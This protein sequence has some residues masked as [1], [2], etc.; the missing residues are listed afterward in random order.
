MKTITRMTLIGGAVAVALGT[1]LAPSV[2]LADSGEHYGK[3]RGG[4]GA[5]MLERYDSNEDGALTQAEIDAAREEQRARFDANGDGTLTLEEYQAM[6][7]DARRER[8]V[9]GFQALDADGD[10]VITVEEFER[11]ARNMVARL[12]RNGDDQLTRDDMRE[13]GEHGKKRRRW[14]DDD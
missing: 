9:D 8:M 13:R 10:G 1:A 3:H 11:P 2:G 6:W 7:I 5:R 12:D 4:H 14:H